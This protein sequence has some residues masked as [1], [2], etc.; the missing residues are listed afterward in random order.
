MPSHI[1]ATYHL[2]YSQGHKICILKCSWNY[3]EWVPT[4]YVP[5]IILMCNHGFSLP[6]VSP[7]FTMRKHSPLNRIEQINQIATKLWQHESNF[8]SLQAKHPQPFNLGP[9][10]FSSLVGLNP[11]LLEDPPLKASTNPRKL[12]LF[13]FSKTSNCF[14]VKR[15][16]ECY[17]SSF[18]WSSWSSCSS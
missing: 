8:P 18:S 17:F 7:S 16:F 1:G 5:W 4:Q 15:I 14:G 2:L 11:T 3:L 9:I 12:S 10:K 13:I 6:L